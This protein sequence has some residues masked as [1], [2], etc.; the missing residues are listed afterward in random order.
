MAFVVF[1]EPLRDLEEYVLA[2]RYI[3]SQSKAKRIIS[4]GD[5]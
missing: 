1:V 4:R 3:P 5:Y 2:A